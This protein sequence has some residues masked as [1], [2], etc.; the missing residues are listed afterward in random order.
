MAVF[1][2]ILAVVVATGCL[3]AIVR[4]DLNTSG[5]SA[6]NSGKSETSEK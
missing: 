5:E 3:F 6:D 1:V 4:S 2:S